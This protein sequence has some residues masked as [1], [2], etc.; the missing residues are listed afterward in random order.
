MNYLSYSK[1][2]C[3][4]SETPYISEI[5]YSRI[6][7]YL[8]GFLYGC[9]HCEIPYKGEF[10]HTGS[11]VISPKIYVSEIPWWIFTSRIEGENPW[12]Y[13]IYDA[14]V[15]ISRINFISSEL[16]WSPVGGIYG[17]KFEPHITYRSQ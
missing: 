7:N 17:S 6:M 5:P 2:C 3:V 11:W 8:R 1:V 16:P 14:G 10:P 13:F 12:S 9:V 15:K 4:H